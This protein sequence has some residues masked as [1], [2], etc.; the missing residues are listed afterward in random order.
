VIV[1]RRCLIAAGV[2]MMA[3][4]DIALAGPVTRLRIAG[5]RVFLPASIDG[6]AVEALLDSAAET[7]IVDRSFAARLGL[8]GGAEATARGTGAA[9]AEATLVSG[10]EL[11]V[12][13]VRLRPAA[14]GVIDLGDISRRLAG[15]PI[16]L[17][18]GR[19]LFDAARLAIDLD[20][21]T[22]ATLPVAGARGIRLPLTERRGI[23]GVPV[24]I[25]GIAA[26]ADFDLGNGGTVLIGAAFAA[27][28]RLLDGRPTSTIPG[29]GI[30]GAVRQ[31]TFTLRALDLGGHRFINVPVA[32]DASPTAADA[33]IGVRLLRHF[34]IVTDFAARSLWLDFRR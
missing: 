22:L 5:D 18:I 25:E 16:D 1:G 2:A 20:A 26:Q 13:G 10:V 28:H 31:T 32:I 34:G 30:G 12:A 6:H 11:F 19:D 8:R 24:T 14:I 7:S 9:T 27:R 33:N 3:L 29:G 21:A 17:I 15:G 23:E 4:P